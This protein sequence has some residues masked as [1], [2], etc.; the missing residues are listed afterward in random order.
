M[1]KVLNLQ[2]FVIASF[3]GCYRMFV[4]LSSVWVALVPVVLGG[5]VYETLILKVDKNI[6]E[7]LKGIVTQMNRFDRCSMIVDLTA[8]NPGA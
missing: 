2:K 4:A 8:L 5:V 3:V 1:H 7:D 6:Y